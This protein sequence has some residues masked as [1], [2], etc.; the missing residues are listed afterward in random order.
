MLR[1]VFALALA[2]S[3]TVAGLGFT[4]APANV[5]PAGYVQVTS[6]HGF[7]VTSGHGFPVCAVIA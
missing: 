7:P 5:C 2:A 6:G 4:A 1:I 3:A